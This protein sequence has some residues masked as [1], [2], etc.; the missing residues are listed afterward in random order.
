MH[1][2]SIINPDTFRGETMKYQ[3]DQWNLQ[4]KKY[5][6]LLKEY[7]RKKHN[8][9]CKHLMIEN[10]KIHQLLEQKKNENIKLTQTLKEKE[11]ELKTLKQ[12]LN[13]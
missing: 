3:G 7:Q 6:K 13:K 2:N 5:E 9:E 11:A 4:I 1:I 10:K 8:N 12:L